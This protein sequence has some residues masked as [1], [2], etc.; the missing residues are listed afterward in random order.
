[1]PHFFSAHF[2]AVAFLQQLLPYMSGFEAN[3]AIGF[4]REVFGWGRDA[5]MVIRAA[6]GF[7]HGWIMNGSDRK[8]KRALALHVISDA[9]SLFDFC[10]LPRCQAFI[11]LSSHVT[12]Y[13]QILS[14]CGLENTLAIPPWSCGII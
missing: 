4:V 13:S 8:A 7:H 2:P 6:Q 5:E 9:V 11:Q 3:E 10:S 1:M 14:F 12:I